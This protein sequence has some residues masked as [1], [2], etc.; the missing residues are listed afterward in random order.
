MTQQKLD[1]IECT[2]HQ[3]STVFNLASRAVTDLVRDGIVPRSVSGKYNLLDC[4]NSYVTYLQE[5]SVNAKS[6]STDY[7]SERI[8][9]KTLQADKLELEVNILRGELVPTELV[10]Q[11]LINLVSNARAKLLNLPVRISHVAIAAE[12]VHEIEIKAKQIIVEAL[13]ELSSDKLP[14][15]LQLLETATDIDGVAMGG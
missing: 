14:E 9:A 7:A 3:I 6:Y 11:A 4:V 5:N 10:E 13:S 15:D 12:S 1:D 2:L 8:R